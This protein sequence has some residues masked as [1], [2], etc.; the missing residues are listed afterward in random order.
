M[1][2]FIIASMSDAI[3]CKKKLVLYPVVREI[4]IS[5]CFQSSFTI[6]ITAAIYNN[7]QKLFTVLQL[8]AKLANMKKIY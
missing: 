3:I 2:L 5:I 8:G 6:S 4:I 1:I 7:F